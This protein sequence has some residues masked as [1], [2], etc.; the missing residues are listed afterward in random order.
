[1]Y[2]AQA[3]RFA[4]VS[5]V[6]TCGVSRPPQPSAALS[7]AATS[8]TRAKIL[9][10]MQTLRVLREPSPDRRVLV[11]GDEAWPTP[12]PLVRVGDRWRFATE[13]GV[14]ELANRRIVVDENSLHVRRA[15]RALCRY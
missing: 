2:V 5:T 15:E 6:S 4:S 9:A 10:A 8:A 11:I 3:A 7:R 12:I 1:M 13:L 14:D